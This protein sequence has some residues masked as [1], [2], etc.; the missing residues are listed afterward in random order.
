MKGSRKSRLMSIAKS[1]DVIELSA[2]WVPDPEEHLVPVPRSLEH[3][4]VGIADLMAELEG[5]IARNDVE[6]S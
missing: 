2:N 3:V 6:F 5:E 1:N 4:K